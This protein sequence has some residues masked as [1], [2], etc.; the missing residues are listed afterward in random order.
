MNQKFNFEIS[1]PSMEHFILCNKEKGQ[2]KKELFYLECHFGAYSTGDLVDDLCVK[3]T[4]VVHV[5]HHDREELNIKS[6][7][8]TIRLRKYSK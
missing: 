1:K 3:A 4:T 8:I 6:P 7:L 5:S 2:I